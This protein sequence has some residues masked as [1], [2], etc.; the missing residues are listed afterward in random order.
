MHNQAYPVICRCGKE[1]ARISLHGGLSGRKTRDDLNREHY[2]VDRE[3][4]PKDSTVTA[5]RG[6]VRGAGIV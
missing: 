1:V 2:R 6:Y 5:G 4:N 3:H